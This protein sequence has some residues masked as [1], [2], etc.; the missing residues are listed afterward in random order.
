MNVTHARQ[1]RIDQINKY[2]II[3]ALGITPQK[4]KEDRHMTLLLDCSGSMG[5]IISE[6]RRDAEKFVAELDTKTFVS[7]IVFS[8][9]GRART[10]AGPTR[11]DES[12]R[13]MVI[14][15]IQDNVHIMDVT[16]FSE[17]LELA[18][19][20]VQKIAND[21]DNQ[22]TLFTDG[23][24]VPTKWDV[25]K[26][27]SKAEAAA[28]A[29]ANTGAGFSVIGYGTWYDADFL[30]RLMAETGHNGLYRHI[31]EVEDFSAAINEIRMTFEK[32]VRGSVDVAIKPNEGKIS[33]FVRVTPEVAMTEGSHF[34]SSAFFNGE[35]T[36]FIETSKEVKT[37]K[38]D[39]R[40]NGKDF[41]E[42]VS[43]KAMTD[44]DKVSF[45]RAYAAQA[46]IAGENST[47][48]EYLEFTGDSG[49]AEKVGNAYTDRESR[50][51]KDVMRRV[52]TDGKRFI[53]TG[54][55]PVGPNHSVL[56]VLRVLIEDKGS[57]L[58]IP[59]GAY[60]RGGELTVD[61]AVL[62]GSGER[63]L[64]VLDMISTEDR[65]NFS[66]RTT[67][68]VKVLPR[69][70]KG[71]VIANATPENKKV[72]R[73]YN[74]IRDGNLVLPELDARL[75]QESFDLLVEAGVIK[76]GTKYEAAKTYTL[77]LRDLKLISPAWAKP[78]TLGLVSLM[79]QEKDLEAA[80]KALNARK[81]ELVA[82]GYKPK[83]D[84]ESE[85]YREQSKKDEA[86]ETDTY[87]ATTVE[88]RLMK[89]EPKAFDASALSWEEANELVKE[90]RRDLSIVRFKIRATT[91]AMERCKKQASIKWSNPKTTAKGTI[92]QMADFDGAKLKRAEKTQTFIC[93]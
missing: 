73:T 62:Q 13:K 4:A 37:V 65:F 8:G 81:K 89:Y 23:C 15:A 12:G 41:S 82:G 57:V 76:A 46:T 75:S 38:I 47:A 34:T 92:E 80:Q 72:Y 7:V 52:F 3:L 24:A 63:T 1:G 27:Q 59:K 11:C 86:R 53:G 78:A 69:D 25:K 48:A 40:V 56:N 28:R 21:A 9:H 39:G 85:F 88:L 10:I 19:K 29:I 44:D 43:L 64:E 77:N 32:T 61:P 49:L 22:V 83:A 16:V 26:E 54:L 18:L 42:T 35:A 14:Q 55:K 31:S 84:E 50:E 5:S 68:D 33:R 66:L 87:T 67:K 91:F 70:E 71:E 58:Y 20:T 90:T 79:R 93:S 36:L 74:V 6:L 60:K 45:I 2:G 51:A 30:G 17:P